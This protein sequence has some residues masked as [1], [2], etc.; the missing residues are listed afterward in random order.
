[1]L[2]IINYKLPTCLQAM[3]TYSSISSSGAVGIKAS[4]RGPLGRVP[5]RVAL[6]PGCVVRH[7][8]NRNEMPVS[9]SDSYA[10]LFFFTIA[11][12]PASFSVVTVV[13]SRP[14]F[15]AVAS[16]LGSTFSPLIAFL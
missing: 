1:M 6:H 8:A 16:I 10:L 12:M 9:G 7:L 14:V 3:P 11:A 15:T 13:Q 2:V 5:A 4:P